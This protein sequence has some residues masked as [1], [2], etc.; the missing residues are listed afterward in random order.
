MKYQKQSKR[1]TQH[2]IKLSKT[3]L[4]TAVNASMV[5]TSPPIPLTAD[6]HMLVPSGGDWSNTELDITDEQ[7]GEIIVT[8]TE[9]SHE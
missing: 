5:S 9:E 3:D 2:M 4:V 1:T 7:G 8:W 6:I